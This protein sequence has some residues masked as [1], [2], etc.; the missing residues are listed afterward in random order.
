[1]N[2]ELMKKFSNPQDCPVR[3]VVDRI[4]DKWSMLVLLL[5]AEEKVLR[6]NE[7][8]KYIGTISQKMLAV[9]L[10]SLESDGLVN[11]TVYPQIPPKVEYQLTSRGKSLLPHLQKLV[12]WAKDNM[13]DIQTSRQ[14]F[15]QTD[16]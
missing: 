6:F 7:I 1:M 4:G 5:L 2:E 13:N 16:D 12:S 15:I 14:N 10:K 8:H 3:N 9:T 11:R